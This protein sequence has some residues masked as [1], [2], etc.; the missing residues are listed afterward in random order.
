MG[1]VWAHPRVQQLFNL[2][3]MQALGL[4]HSH[5]VPKVRLHMFCHPL[6]GVPQCCIIKGM[7][8]PREGRQVNL[9]QVGRPHGHQG[10]LLRK[11]VSG[12]LRNMGEASAERDSRGENTM[13]LSSKE[14]HQWWYLGEHWLPSRQ[15][16]VIGS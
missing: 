3:D 1:P 2:P 8:G 16:L 12:M 11:R 10:R 4:E 9:Q 6:F 5:E 13:W 14:G 15:W 7:L